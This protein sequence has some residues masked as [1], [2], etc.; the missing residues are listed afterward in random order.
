MGIFKSFWFRLV[1]ALLGALFIE[2]A[3][4]FTIPPTTTLG[5]VLKDVLSLII[6]GFIYFKMLKTDD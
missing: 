4:L 1:I 3:I 5:I 2:L 6:F